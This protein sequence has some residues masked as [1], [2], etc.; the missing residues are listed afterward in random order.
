[1]ASSSFS[2]SLLSF[3]ER[4]VRYTEEQELAL[5]ASIRMNLQA[6]QKA[7]HDIDQKFKNI[8][9]EMYVTAALIN[10]I[11]TKTPAVKQD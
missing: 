8:Q 7:T 10:A 5:Y 1:M 3:D 4:S 11:E 6:I 9:E 2:S